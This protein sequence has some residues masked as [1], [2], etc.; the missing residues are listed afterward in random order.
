M[1]TQVL[2]RKNKRPAANKGRKLVIL[3]RGQDLQKPRMAGCGLAFLVAKVFY[4]A[5]K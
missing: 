3:E 5:C 2:A 1:N 4:A